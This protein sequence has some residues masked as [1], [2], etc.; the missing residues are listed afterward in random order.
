LAALTLLGGGALYGEGSA[1]AAATAGPTISLD[2]LTTDQAFNAFDP[3]HALA[4]P[5]VTHF[6]LGVQ[7][8][9]IYFSF[10]G[11]VAGKTTFHVNFL[12]NDTALRRGEVHPLRSV[13]G[14][15]LLDLPGT[16]RLTAGD[17]Q[18]AVYL[19]AHRAATTNFSIVKTPIVRS[20]Y[21]IDGTAVIRFN[22]K[23]PVVPARAGSVKAG[24]KQ[25]G[26]YVSYRA[27]VHGDTLAIAVYDRYGR[28][29]A[30]IGSTTLTH[31]PTGALALL[32]KPTSGSYPA[33][34]YRI[35]IVLDGAVTR[36]VPWQAR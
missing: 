32:L 14:T 22:V 10:K 20:A 1:R 24:T 26:V 27:A 17:Y 8:V 9:A 3:S 7:Y 31:H 18:A 25:V 36:S 34:I 13:D 23:H 30:S 6:P 4:P 29:V 35:D 2:Y 16:G 11:A 12:K 33:G 28:P 5:P 15:Y 19:D 21:L